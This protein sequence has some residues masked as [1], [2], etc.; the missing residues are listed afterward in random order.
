MRS[1]SFSK[2]RSK[3]VEVDGI[4][5]DSKKEANRYL[6][7]KLLERSGQIQNLRM[8]VPFELI[9]NQYEEHIEFTKTGKE[10]IVKKLVERKCSYIADFV[11]E[12][13]GKTVVE[14][15]KGFRD[16]T[17]YALF[18]IKRKLVLQLYGIKVVEV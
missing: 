6:E 15:A 9:P 14:D 7:L 1:K 4:Q 10:K 2:Y 18:V 17:A 3:K 5:F 12:E 16:S 8:Q 13:D 11:Y